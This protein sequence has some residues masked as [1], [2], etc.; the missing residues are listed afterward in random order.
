[1][2]QSPN[3][4]NASQN[5]TP[6]SLTRPK[7]Q[8]L[9]KSAIKNSANKVSSNMNNSISEPPPTGSFQRRM[10]FDLNAS[11]SKPLKYKQY[12]GK[13]KP[14]DFNAKSLFLASLATNNNE[15]K[16][17]EKSRSVNVFKPITNMNDTVTKNKDVASPLKKR[18]SSQKMGTVRSEVSSTGAS[19]KVIV[20]ELSKN[21]NM[22]KEAE[23]ANLLK[24]L[25]HEKIKMKKQVQAD[26]NRNLGEPNENVKV[27]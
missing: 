23:K 13:L 20:T 10:S 27:A 25:N 22:R 2:S 7:M 9:L 15:T 1:M 19:A 18:L 12:T 16:V 5:K 17:I 21:E 14:V 4:M 24:K 26:K 11:L 3:L 8:S 6:T